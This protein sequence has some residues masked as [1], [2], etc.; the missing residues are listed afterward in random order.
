MRGI[1]WISTDLNVGPA[2]LNVYNCY[3]AA[4][5]TERHVELLGDTVTIK[6]VTMFPGHL[7][8][9][10]AIK[11]GILGL[12]RIGVIRLERIKKLFRI[13]NWFKSSVS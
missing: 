10:G 5:P 13:D 7:T 1:Y 11:W 2:K 3:L 8:Y 6:N 12:L 4:N 9:F